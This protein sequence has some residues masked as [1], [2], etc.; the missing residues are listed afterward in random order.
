MG[1]ILARA[2]IAVVNLPTEK[3]EPE[4][5]GGSIGGYCYDVELGG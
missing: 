3:G 2:P 1:E 5:S 4:P